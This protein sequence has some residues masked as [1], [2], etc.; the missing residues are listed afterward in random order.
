[1]GNLSDS[2]P[3]RTFIEIRHLGRFGCRRPAEPIFV[4]GNGT[5]P[6]QSENHVVADP[7]LLKIQ[8]GIAPEAA[9]MVQPTAAR[10]PTQKQLDLNIVYTESTIYDPG[11]GRYDEVR[12]SSW[13]AGRGRDAT[14]EFT[15]VSAWLC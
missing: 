3:M 12:C 13:G 8:Q 2:F 10:L 7:P 1:M 11:A 9:L 5:A 14:F 6:A 15:G 4:S